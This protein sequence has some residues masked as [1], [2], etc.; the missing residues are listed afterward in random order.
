MER[1]TTY[2]KR[3][4]LPPEILG[5]IQSKKRTKQEYVRTL[6]PKNKDWIKQPNKPS[7][8]I[9]KKIQKPKIELWNKRTHN[10][11]P[12]FIETDKNYYQKNEETQTRKRKEGEEESPITIEEV[13]DINIPLA[14]NRASGENNTNNHTLKNLPEAGMEMIKEIA[15][16]ALW[17]GNTS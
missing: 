9:T 3:K 12:K 10:R 5:L 11:R 17:A 6:H 7:K 13:N 2:Q 1:V 15:E 4:N 14:K 8:R 16:I